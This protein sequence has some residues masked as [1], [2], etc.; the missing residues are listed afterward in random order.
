M[1][2]L[3]VR[4]ICKSFG[5]L[6]AISDLSFDVNAG[7][8]FG[9]IGPNGAGKSTLFN[10]ATSIYKPE[11]G[12]IYLGKRRITGK[13]SHQICRMGISRTF[14][15]VKTFLSMTAFENVLVGS[16]YGHRLR[17]KEAHREAEAALDLV[18]LIEQKDVVTAHMTLSDRRLLEVA[19]ALAS[20]PLL[21]LLDEPMAGLNPS[22]IVNMLQIIEKA[23]QE[24][25]VSILWVEHKVDAIFRLCDRVAVLDY[26]RKIGEGKPEEIAQNS[27][28][29]EAYL[30]R[31]SS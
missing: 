16:I 27:K 13:P 15:L 14:Q 2:I 23:R 11:I 9:I 17:G 18:G 12:D 8:I 22:E 21:T 25:N 5:G 3:E 1:S 30:G 29:I 31:P 7:E 4:N 10:V 26:G 19:R 6:E 20:K 24:R 28:V